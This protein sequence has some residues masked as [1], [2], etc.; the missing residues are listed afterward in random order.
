[1]IFVYEP[2]VDTGPP[3]RRD[4]SIGPPG[5]LGE[6]GVEEG[7]VDHPDP[8]AYKIIGQLDGSGMDGLG[9]LGQTV[10]AV[11][12]R[13][14]AGRHREQHLRSAD[15]GGRLLPADVLLPGLQ[16]QA[17]GGRAITI[18]RYPDQPPWQGAFQARADGNESG[19][20]STVEERNPEPLAR[21]NSQIRTPL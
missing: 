16:S 12:D 3:P 17:E 20:R 10:R 2:D 1:M 9:D 8:S 7:V 14:H 11:I 21:P 18:P 19:V 6:H 13:V 4:D 15:V 5:N